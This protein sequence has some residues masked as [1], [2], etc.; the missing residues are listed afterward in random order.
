MRFPHRVPLGGVVRCSVQRSNVRT[1]DSC[2]DCERE[3]SRDATIERERTFVS[4]VS[5]KDRPNGLLR[6]RSLLLPYV[7][8]R[9]EVRHAEGTRERAVGRSEAP[10]GFPSRELHSPERGEEYVVVDRPR[11][12]RR[13]DRTLRE[14]GDEVGSRRTGGG[15]VPRSFPHSQTNERRKEHDATY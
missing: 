9:N 5:N 14:V 13:R 6:E 8:E 1:I 10:A 3:R 4:L 2:N 15:F 7:Y 12:R 11:G